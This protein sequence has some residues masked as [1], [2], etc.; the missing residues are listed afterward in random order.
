MSDLVFISFPT[1]QQAEEVRNKVLSLQR[2]YLI[3]LGDAV[4]V[5]K[6][7]AGHIKLNQLM[8]L[9]TTG[10]ASGA[11]W[12]TLIGFIFMAPLLGTALGAASGALGGRLSDVGINDK[13]MTDAAAALK[14]NTAG[15][16]L[17]IRKMTTDKVL[18]DLRGSGGTL[19]STSFDETKEAALR[20]AL[21]AA[22]PSETA[23]PAAT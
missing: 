7:E 9:T 13:F 21:A 11:L 19:I 14:P 4:V 10:A 3:E 8:N 5:V 1:E 22:A 18:A 15:L 6:N 20:E 12:G 2:E 16:F 17:L 23:A